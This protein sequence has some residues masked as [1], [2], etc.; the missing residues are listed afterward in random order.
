MGRRGV[1][2]GLAAAPVLVAASASAAA[3]T[4][5]GPA[6]GQGAPGRP[7]TLVIGHRGASGYRP[8]HTL[9]SYELAARLGADF[10]EPDLVVTKDGHLVCRHEPEI[11]GTTNVADHPEFAARKVTKTLDG[12][13]LT[14][15]FTEDFTLAEL[16]TLRAKERIPDVRQHNTL[17]NG[18][19]EIPTLMEVLDLR[20]RLSAE[21]G[22]QIGVYPET[23]HPTYFQKAGLALEKRLLDTLVRYGLNDKNA[24]VFVQSFETKNL[25]QLRKLGLKTRAVQLLSAAG[26]PFDLV[27]AGDPRTYADLITPAGLKTIATYANGIGPDKNQIIPRDAG[28]NLAT[29]T[30]LVADAHKAGLVL[31]PY[32]FRAENS[33]LPADY[34]VGTVASDYGRAI[35]E[36]VTFLKTG[37]DGLFTDNTDVGI[38]ARAAFLGG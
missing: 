25:G 33:F 4:G 29:P 23:K 27:D 32:T 37:I 21:L 20:K 5:S 34:R 11:G 12:V 18:R 38:L 35:D 1:I 15:W 22:R 6:G 8:E 14:G 3:A 26:A 13:A 2:A 7:A 9:A 10:V 28:G 19:F 31:H 24:P 16:K 36:Q 17:Y 30:T